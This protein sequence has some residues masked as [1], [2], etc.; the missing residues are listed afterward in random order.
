[1]RLLLMDR[2]RL[3]RVLGHLVAAADRRSS[4]VAGDP[5]AAAAGADD[6]DE[7]LLVRRAAAA[8]LALDNRG[9][10]ELT[11]AGQLA[12]HI[13]RGFEKYGFYVL[14]GARRLLLGHN[15]PGTASAAHEHNFNATGVIQREELLELR[16]DVDNLL[17]R[18][19]V[20]ADGEL[21]ARGRPAA[22]LVPPSRWNLA[23]PLSDPTGGRGRAPGTRMRTFTPGADA[24]VMVPRSLAKCLPNSDAALRLFG[25]PGLLAAAAT[26]KGED[27]APGAGPSFQ[28][29]LPGLGPAVAWHQD[30]PQGFNFMAQLWGSTAENGVWLLPGSHHDGP[31]DILQ[32]EEQYDGDRFPGAVP[33]VAAAGDVCIASRMSLHCSYPN[34]SVD[35]R[36]TLNIGFATRDDVL[37]QGAA[38]GKGPEEVE[39]RSRLIPIAMAARAERW[40][41]EAPF[42][43]PPGHPCCAERAAEEEWGDAARRVVSEQS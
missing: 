20:S 40:P 30:G 7:S 2:G 27:F 23:A 11:P 6:E 8:A 1:L 25:H 18:A 33:M 5:A 38:Q 42:V 3:A 43:L 12:P 32:L 21:D 41:R 16:A 35:K 31:I 22:A 39:E 4:S 10:L 29:K 34:T 17:E 19:P 26:L 28:I 36:I 24:P 14:E 37:E 15:L 9:P 13:V